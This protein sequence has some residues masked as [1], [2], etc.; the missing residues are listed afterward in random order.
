[1]PEIKLPARLENLDTLL[2]FIEEGVS[3]EEFDKFLLYKILISADEILTNIISYAYPD[4][5]GDLLLRYTNQGESLSIDI[6]DWGIPFDPLSREKPDLDIQIE[7]RQIGG[8]GVY[9]TKDLM[10]RVEYKREHDRNILT[11]MIALGR[12]KT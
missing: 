11:L 5:D 8:L 1:M 2:S 3:S 9:M 7:G 6:I 10:D 12:D 4:G